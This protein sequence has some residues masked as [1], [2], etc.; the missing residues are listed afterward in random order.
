M[1]LRLARILSYLLHPLLI[2]TYTT[3]FLLSRPPS[4]SSSI[5]PEA[6][7]WLTILVF[8]FTFLLPT[9][10]ILLM[11]HFRLVDSPELDKPQQRTI[12]LIFTFISY[13]GL[14]YVIR[15]SNLPDYFLFIIYG[16]LF[17]LLVGLLI[18]LAYKISQHTLAWGAL[19]GLFAGLA[20][21]QGLDMTMIICLIILISGL[22]GYARLRLNAH[23]PAQ[24]Y[25]GFI[26]GVVVTGVMTLAL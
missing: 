10:I 26:T 18:N 22:V 23:T 3:L 20:I 2:P 7:I 21:H 13:Y 1:E 5:S 17:T 8:V 4:L 6:K 11:Y 25:L 14:L 24:V 12:P 19:S 15:D 9:V 16:S